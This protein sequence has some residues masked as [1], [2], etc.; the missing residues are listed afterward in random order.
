MFYGLDVHKKFIQVCQLSRNGKTRREFRIDAT[1]EAIEAFAKKLNGRDHVA[2]EAT[3]HT[4]AIHSL[5]EPHAGR[6]VVVNP[7][8]VKAIAHAKI[9]T[10]KVDAHTLAELLRADYLPTVDMPDEKTWTLRQLVSHRRFLVK[11][12]TA[13]KNTIHAILNRRLIVAPDG[14]PFS[15]KTRRWMRKLS[16]P[17]A[18]RFLLDN[19][20]DLLEQ[21][22]AR[23]A[24][25]DEQLLRHASVEQNAHLLMTIPGIHITVAIG[26]L[27]AIGDI[28]RFPAPG[29]LAAY[30]G[31]VPKVSQSAGRCYYGRIT[32]AGNSTA[33][34]LSIEAAQALVR[35]SSPV[36]ATYHRVQRK[37]GHNVAVTALARKLV[38]IIWHMLQNQEPYRYAPATRTWEKLRSVVPR[39]PHARVAR[40]PRTL[41]EI[42][43]EAGLP[44]LSDPSPGERRAAANNRRTCTRLTRDR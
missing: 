20:L 40:L 13:A 42:Y 12:Q 21:V 15:G 35:S 11:Q 39:P 28:R 8:R 6:V 14:S 7:L 29:K 24:A 25:A 17:A 3:F 34:S 44:P 37:R 9:K 2:L 4:W 26:L 10:D 31:L 33:R 43:D 41:E 38:T 22:E 23:V 18:E 1:F 27:S 36:T 5:L 16:L 32:K 30:F 19:A